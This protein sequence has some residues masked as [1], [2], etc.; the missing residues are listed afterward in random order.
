MKVFYFTGTGNSLSVAKQMGGELYNIATYKQKEVNDDESIGIVFP[1]FCYNIPIIVKDFLKNTKLNAPYIWAIGTCGS[2][3]GYSFISINK[4]L[5]AQGKNL[6]YCAKIV[7]PDSCMI[8]ATPL[9]KQQPMLDREQSLVTSFV[10][11]I[12]SKKVVAP[13]KDKPFNIDKLAWWGIKNIYG[14]KNKATNQKCNN[15]GICAKICPT[16]NITITDKPHFGNVCETCFAC[17]QWCPEGAIEF[18]KKLQI[19]NKTKYN[20]PNIKVAELIKRNNKV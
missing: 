19:D 10:E 1:V 5:Q 13:F 4:L 8:F 18:G 20:H 9:E 7:L 12:N 6:S 2:S 11:D 15:C 14:T 16:N 3:V 17:I